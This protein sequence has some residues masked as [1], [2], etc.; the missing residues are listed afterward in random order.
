MEFEKGRLDKIIDPMLET[1]CTA[2]KRGTRFFQSC[3]PLSSASFY[4][5]TV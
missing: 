1:V 5:K 2:R 3:P 4:N